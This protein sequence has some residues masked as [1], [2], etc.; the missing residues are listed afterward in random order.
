MLYDMTNEPDSE[1]D[2][3]AARENARNRFQLWRK[4]SAY[5][6]ALTLLS[7]AAVYPFVNGRQLSFDGEA[8]KQVLLLLSLGLLIATL[9]CAMLMWGAWQ[10][11][12]E[13]K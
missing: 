10:S 1:E 7:F 13:L 3:Q 9:Y 12:R 8:V 2:L 4:R 11:L 6:T 5:S